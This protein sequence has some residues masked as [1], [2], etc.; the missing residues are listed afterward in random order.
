MNVFSVMNAG[1]REHGTNHW[2][3][4]V[5]IEIEQAPD[6]TPEADRKSRPYSK[7]NKTDPIS[8]GFCSSRKEARLSAWAAIKSL[9]PERP[10]AYEYGWAWQ[11][12]C[13]ERES[14]KRPLFSRC[15][16]GAD[17]WLWVV[18]ESW[19]CYWETDPIA[20]GYAATSELALEDAQRLIGD[21][22]LASNNMAEHFRTKQAATKRSQRI[23]STS[24]AATLEFVY[25]CHRYY[26][27][28]DGSPGDHI[29]PHRI[30]K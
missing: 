7:W 6:L 16:V 22:S 3:W 5:W 28:Y 14:D 4:A 30:V 15:S 10:R 19:W 13:D 25:E 29:Q 20:Y 26:C 2:F 1:K 23:A 24:E 11:M 8:S 27:D 21:V 17:K 18:H 12:R 9:C